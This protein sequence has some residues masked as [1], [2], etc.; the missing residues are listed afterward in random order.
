MGGECEGVE[1]QIQDGR[2]HGETS[3]SLWCSFPQP[4]H[5]PWRAG[6]EAQD[7]MRAGAT[8]NDPEQ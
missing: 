2:D 7:T 4:Q 1:V 5:P 8:A 3:G 6:G